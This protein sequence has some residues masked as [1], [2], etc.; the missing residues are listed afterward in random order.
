MFQHPE[1]NSWLEMISTPLV[2]Q[3]LNRGNQHLEE[4]DTQE[5]IST[6]HLSEKHYV[7]NLPITNFSISVENVTAT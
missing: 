3:T 4:S 6:L 5:N 7:F 2:A 1:Y